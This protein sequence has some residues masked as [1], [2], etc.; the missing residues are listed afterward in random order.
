MGE[1]EKKVKCEQMRHRVLYLR[2]RTLTH[3]KQ[4]YKRRDQLVSDGFY[5][6]HKS[7]GIM[8]VVNQNKLHQFPFNWRIMLRLNF[9]CTDN[10]YA[11][12]F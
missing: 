10:I 2:A 8:E 3:K 6:K 9:L 1:E 12:T 11:N 4:V 7:F 5:C